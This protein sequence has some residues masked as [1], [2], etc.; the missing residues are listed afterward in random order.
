MALKS[1]R[2]DRQETKQKAGAAV[3]RNFGN[4]GATLLGGKVEFRYSL[5][6]DS[7]QDG[8]WAEFSNVIGAYILSV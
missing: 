7:A 2:G 8:G 5:R 3:F 6:I 1:R 4:V